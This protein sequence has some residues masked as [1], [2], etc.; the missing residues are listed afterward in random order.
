VSRVKETAA[1][2]V[3]R[4][5]EEHAARN[6]HRRELL[7][8][9]A[10]DVKPRPVS[11]LWDG[12]IPRGCV[13]LIPGQPGVGKSQLLSLLAAQVSLG[14]LPGDLEGHPA[15]AVLLTAEDALRET[16]I[17]RLMA[18]NADRSR[19]IFTS[20]AQ[21]GGL[22]DTLDLQQDLAQLQGLV[23]RTQ[24]VMVGIDPFGSFVDGIDSHKDQQVRRA[25]AALAAMAEAEQVAVV[26]VMH[27]NKRAGEADA[28]N[29]I[30]GSIAWGALAR[31]A[32]MVGR[33]GE[34]GDVHLVHIKCN[35]A[36]LSPSQRCRIE[37]VSV[38]SGRHEIPTSRL[39]IEGESD[40]QAHDLLSA[41]PSVEERGLKVEAGEWLTATLAGGPM[42]VPELFA[43]AKEQGFSEKTLQ[44]A[45]EHIGAVAQQTRDGWVWALP[46]DGAP[47][48]KKAKR[49]KSRN[50]Q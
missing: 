30:S 12:R 45:K 20:Q 39:V 34:S 48:R 19:V 35:L 8:L 28:L 6:G 23:R 43:K 41:P 46:A 37:S 11:W 42:R 22:V 17:P 50:K 4:E 27:L 9:R 49:H 25:L 47:K 33:D 40:V 31:S 2:R 16:A 29:R 18:N 13:T 44:R 15:S 1:E 26:G 36:A 10:S 14:T 21:V 32:L 38:T 24:A 5:V 7:V 3:E